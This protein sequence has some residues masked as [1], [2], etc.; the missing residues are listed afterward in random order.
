MKRTK[1]I[2]IVIAVGLCLG[3][4]LAFQNC[5]RAKFNNPDP[6]HSA[7][8]MDL[9]RYCS[10]ETGNGV[11]CRPNV[12]VAFSSCVFE[13]CNSGFQLAGAFCTPVTCSQGSIANCAVS[14]GEGRMICNENQQ[15]Y[16]S[17]TAVTCDSGF[18]LEN[19]NCSPIPAACEAGSHRDC[20]TDSTIGI[21][22]CNDEGTV[23]GS[24]EF[25][26]CKPGFNK[27]SSESCIPNICEPNTMTPCTVGAGSGFQ[28]CN[29]HGSAWGSCVLNG[30]QPGY[31]LQ[32]GVCVIQ[33]CSP[34]ESSV[35][36]FAHG[37]G[38]KICNQNGTDYGACTLV[39]CEEGF[40][41]V[42][43]KCL[44]KH[45]TPAAASSCQGESGSGQKFCY[46]NGQGYGPCDLTTCDPG[47]K[48]KGH[49][50]VAEN[51]CD[52]GETLVCTTQNGSGLRTC[53]SHD[54]VIGPCVVDHCNSGFELVTQGGNP[55]C[56]KI[57]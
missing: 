42:D 49:Q 16:G 46:E 56:K 34:G 19:G 26:D 53:N 8:A 10:N 37:S 21:E 2:S 50:C 25:G 44:E 22:T 41:V 9:C 35:C 38:E 5:A 20:S 45:C 48:L 11:Q 13:S 23:Y 31:N 33:L 39:S 27:D 18:N 3:I 4:G 57:K 6:V 32:D 29:S 54:H 47:F 36:E 40:L 55:A 30:C 24:C 17:C 12:N 14:H 28:N 1:I 51:S 43:G 7:F 52:D 15:G